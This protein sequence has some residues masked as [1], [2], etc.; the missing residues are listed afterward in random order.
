LRNSR[1]VAAAVLNEKLE[2]SAPFAVGSAESLDTVVL[3]A[4]AAEPVARAFAER[5]VNVRRA[6][7]AQA[8]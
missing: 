2:T 4:G 6:Q 3:E 7:P 5:G 1:R 8:G